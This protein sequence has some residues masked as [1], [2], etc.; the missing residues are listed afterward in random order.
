MGPDAVIIG[1]FPLE[2]GRMGVKRKALTAI[3][4]AAL[5]AGI[6]ASAA[7][8]AHRADPGITA[9]SIK[10]GGTFP[11]TGVAS[12][13]KTIPFAEKAYFDYTNEL[14]EITR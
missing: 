12:L 8:G 4:A 7:P 14:K 11:L 9:T 5:I 1:T 3:A 13:Y 6:V 10:I 2:E